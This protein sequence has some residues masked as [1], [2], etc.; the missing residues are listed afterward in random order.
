MIKF[1]WL[2]SV[3]ILLQFNLIIHAQTDNSKIL[4]VYFSVPETDD[5][6]ASTGASRV[7]VDEKLYGT[8]EYVAKQIAEIT[9]G[10]I[11]EIKTVHAYPDKNHKDLINYAKNEAET[12]I[13]PEIQSKITN[14]DDY[15][16]I[17]VG[18]PNWWYDMPMVIYSLFNQYDF[19]D[20]TIIPFCTHG[21][22]GFSDSVD[23]IRKLEKNAKVIQMPAISRNQATKSRAGLIKW[24]TDNDIIK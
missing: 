2:L 21:G 6:D 23:T 12:K 11:F 4:V 24:L 13:Y 8:T 7:I 22:S 17:F 20:K 16:I 3:I 14:F 10:N 19:K 9:K 5:V 15:N 18:Y 1:K